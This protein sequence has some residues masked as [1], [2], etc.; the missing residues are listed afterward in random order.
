[1]HV[2]LNTY[3]NPLLAGGIAGLLSW[4]FTYPVDVV[5]SRIQSGKSINYHE[6]IRKKNLWKGYSFCAGRAIV[7]NSLGFYIYDLCKN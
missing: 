2:H 5:K 6:A 3:F 1:M 4:T 7:V